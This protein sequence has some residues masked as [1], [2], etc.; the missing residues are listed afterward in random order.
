MEAGTENEKEKKLETEKTGMQKLLGC[1][2]KFFMM[3]GFLVILVVIVV[4][5]V[6]ISYL[7]K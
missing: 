6:L 4:I 2:M 3:G 5:I 1:F 7:T